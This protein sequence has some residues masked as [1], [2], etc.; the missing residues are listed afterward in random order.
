M[1]PRSRSL[2]DADLAALHG[3]VVVLEGELLLDALPPDLNQRLISRL[4]RH[5]PLAEGSTPGTLRAALSVLAQ[6]LQWAMSTDLE[7]PATMADRTTYHLA[8]PAGSVAACITALR[9]AGAEDISDGAPTTHGWEMRPTGP[10]GALERHSIYPADGREV[11]A[12]FAELAPDPAYHERV[13]Q[14]S[15]LAEHHGGKYAGASW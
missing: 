9:E 13:A 10:D 6:R 4:T 1:H 7:Y 11:T 8:I 14:L 5:G 15:A 12:V 2:P 3:V